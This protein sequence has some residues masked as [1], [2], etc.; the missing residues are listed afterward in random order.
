MMNLIGLDRVHK[1]VQEIAKRKNNDYGSGGIDPL[2]VTGLDGLVTRLIDKVARLH[3]LTR[4]GVNRLVKDESIRDTL[5]DMV[6]YASYGV[7]LLD[8]TWGK[9]ENVG[10]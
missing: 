10:S 5:L 7:M 1:E 6:N 8:G 9:D 2:A 3:S 4:P